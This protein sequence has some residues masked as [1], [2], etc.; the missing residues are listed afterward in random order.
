MAASQTVKDDTLEQQI[1][2]NQPKKEW[3]ARF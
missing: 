1:Y 3:L 2:C